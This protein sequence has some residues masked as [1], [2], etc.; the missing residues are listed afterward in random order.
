MIAAQPD[1]LKCRYYFITHEPRQPYGC[2]AMGFKSKK[3][4]SVVVFE[5]SGMACQRYTPKESVKAKKD[6]GWTA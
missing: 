1:C 2:R 5:S 4:P 3:R 6:S